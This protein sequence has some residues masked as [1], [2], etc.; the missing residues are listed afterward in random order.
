MAQAAHTSTTCSLE[1]LARKATRIIN[2]YARLDEAGIRQGDK[3]DNYLKRQMKELSRLLRTI[4]S[5]ALCTKP[6]SSRGLMFLLLLIASRVHV[7]YN[8][9]RNDLQFCEDT[10]QEIEFACGNA[11]GYLEDAFGVDRN[12]VCGDY[13]FGHY[14]DLAASV[15]KAVTA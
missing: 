7:L 1:A 12:E 15:A 14:C 2:A 10:L 9:D 6:R 8:S 3:D 11:I 4:E 5:S 13:Y